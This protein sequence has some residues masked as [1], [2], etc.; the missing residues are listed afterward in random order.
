MRI[1]GSHFMHWIM[2]PYIQT[3]T[4]EFYNEVAK[5]PYFNNSNWSFLPRL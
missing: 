5:Q 2:Q 4:N 1:I 3:H